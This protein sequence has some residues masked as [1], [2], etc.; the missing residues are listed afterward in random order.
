[1]AA[2]GWRSAGPLDSVNSNALLPGIGG[3][4]CQS[5]IPARKHLRHPGEQLA[6]C[7]PCFARTEPGQSKGK[8]CCS[9]RVVGF[10]AAIIA[11][12]SA[13]KP[14]PCHPLDTGKD[15]RAAAFGVEDEIQDPLRDPAPLAAVGVGLPD[16]GLVLGRGG[17][18]PLDRVVP[19][20]GVA[21]LEAVGEKI[22]APGG[23]SGDV[24]T[25]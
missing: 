17:Q 11:L 25:S 15:L 16:P 2:Q 21:R 13:R 9:Q 1:M 23:S 3:A 24:E 22:R 18:R 7:R 4:H 14:C 20:R 6:R 19:G 5:V 10:Q 8:V 12:M